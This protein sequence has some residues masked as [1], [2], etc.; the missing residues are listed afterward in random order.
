M[1]GWRDRKKEVWEYMT[2]TRGNEEEDGR[3]K[4]TNKKD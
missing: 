4:Y 3:G 1:D 2:K